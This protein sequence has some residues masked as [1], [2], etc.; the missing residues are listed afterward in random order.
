MPPF[1]LVTLP[2]PVSTRE[3]KFFL[4]SSHQFATITIS[5]HFACKL[6]EPN[7]S[8]VLQR[9]LRHISKPDPTGTWVAISPAVSCQTSFLARKWQHL[10]NLRPWGC[11]RGWLAAFRTRKWFLRAFKSLGPMAIACGRCSREISLMRHSQGIE[12]H[13]PSQRW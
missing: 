3:P 12:G 7:F 8:W 2:D 13:L 6:S 10:S 1:H 4:S 9:T 5:S 11:D